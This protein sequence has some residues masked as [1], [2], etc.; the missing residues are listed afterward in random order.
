MVITRTRYNEFNDAST[1]QFFNQFNMLLTRTRYNAGLTT[2]FNDSVNEPFNE[3]RVM[4]ES[5][6]APSLQALS[7]RGPIIFELKQAERDK[8]QKSPSVT[9]QLELSV[10]KKEK[11]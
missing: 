3:V 9:L 4:L 8:K 10:M 7:K 6:L 1:S 5:R 11:R 2:Y